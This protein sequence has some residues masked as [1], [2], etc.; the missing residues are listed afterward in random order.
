MKQG[1][2]HYSKQN[3]SSILETLKSNKIMQLD[4][5]MLPTE[6]KFDSIFRK[7][8]LK[9]GAEIIHTKKR[10]ISPLV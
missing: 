8:L 1:F 3:C 2:Y 5:Q 9:C 7:L 6:M 4:V 10:T